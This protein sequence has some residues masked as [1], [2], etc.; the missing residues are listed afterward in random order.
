MSQVL[1]QPRGKYFNDSEQR[2]PNVL[3]YSLHFLIQV[4]IGTTKIVVTEQFYLRDSQT[5]TNFKK[6]NEF[7]LRPSSHLPLRRTLNFLIDSVHWVTLT[8]SKFT[9]VAFAITL[10]SYTQVSSFI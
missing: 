3:S 5:I 6:T 1:E 7:W 8:A 4:F 9:R 2:F 10:S